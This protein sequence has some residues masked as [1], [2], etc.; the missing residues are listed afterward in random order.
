[1]ST[2][3]FLLPVLITVLFTAAAH[4]VRASGE[5][6][7]ALHDYPTRPDSQVRYTGLE[8]HLEAGFDEGTVRG[9]ATYRFHPKHAYLEELAL[10]APGM[11]IRELTINGEQ[12]AYQKRGDTLSIP[13]RENPDTDREHVLSVSYVTSPVFGVHFRHNGTIVSSSLPGSTMHWLPGPAHPG[14]AMPIVTRLEVPG[15]LTGVA[16]G[17]LERQTST[18]KGRLYV[19]RTGVEVPITDLFFA[20]GNFEVDDAFSGT[21]NL[22]VYWE[23]G[24]TDPDQAQ[25]YITFL[26]RRVRDFERLLQSEMPVQAFHAIILSDNMWETR[27]YYAGAAVVQGRPDQIKTMMSRSIAAQWLGI[28]L[29]PEKWDESGHI[30]L[31]QAL[32]AERLGEP[33]WEYATDPMGDAF[34]VPETAYRR[35]GMEA[36]QGSRDFLRKKSMPILKEAMDS[37][38][39]GLAARRG[40]LTSYE[41]SALIYEKTGLWMEIP[42][43]TQPEPKTKLRYLVNAD[44][45]RGSDRFMLTVEPLED[46]TDKELG[47]RV[48]WIRDGEIRNTQLTFSG[49]GDQLEISPGGS[50]SNI[51][52]ESDDAK[53]HGFEIRKPFSHW[54]YQLRRDERPEMRKEAA[55]ALKGYSRDPDLQLAVQDLLNREQD[56]EALAAMHRLMAELT[57]GASGTERRFLDGITSRHEQVRFESMKALQNY[58]NNTQVENQ[59]FSIIQ[60]SD[61]ISLVNEA[62]RT[63][64][65]LVSEE[66]FRDFAIQFLREDRQEQMFT[67]TLISELFE[68]TT[69]DTVLET[70]AEYLNPGYN[71]QLRWLAYRL[72]RQ[73]A[74]GTGWQ[75]GF[76]REYYDD[77]DPRIRFIA[78][79]SIP[80]MNF[81]E[82]GPFLESRMLVEYDIRILLQASV[83]ADAE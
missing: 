1:M 14:P 16:S 17:A 41:F 6:P 71:F 23:Q 54:L 18:D 32:A 60:S 59:V 83:L 68:V 67:E 75:D 66:Q 44:E 61:D 82:R 76:V 70:V 52:V 78:L 28:A 47:I 73:H 4:E 56:P 51:W 63:Y 72:L 62:I 36:W 69:N 53:S 46:I 80:A 25:D 31:L 42:Q 43:A 2:K 81:E 40:V 10:S 49:S 77:P 65:K 27:P 79:F 24:V 8:L 50:I 7:G 38:L 39:M 64:R 3:S 22:R 5:N 58:R 19:F 12:V 57:A 29:R 55:L 20:V 30:T 13:F 74:A 37:A 21:K 45:I 34:V 9:T 15:D 33:D 48:Y 11:Q 35:K 26:T